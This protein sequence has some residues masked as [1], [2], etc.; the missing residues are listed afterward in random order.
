MCIALKNRLADVQSIKQKF[1]PKKQRS[2]FW[3]FAQTAISRP[4]IDVDK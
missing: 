1:N 2:P 3:I 4:R